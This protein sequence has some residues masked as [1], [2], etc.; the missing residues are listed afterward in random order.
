MEILWT[1]KIATSTFKFTLSNNWIIIVLILIGIL[2]GAICAYF[3]D[4]DS[5]FQTIMVL[6]VL[7]AIFFFIIKVVNA[8]ENTK[9][10]N[11]YWV[12]ITDY[13]E[14]AEKI[15]KEYDIVEQKS[16]VLVILK[17]KKEAE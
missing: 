17:D 3:V 9:Y 11:H 1:E 5:V 14:F 4:S 6:Y 12:R 8:P 13:E 7:I 16:E 10:I 15:L 2:I